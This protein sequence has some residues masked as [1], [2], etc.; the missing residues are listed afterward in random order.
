M[1]QINERAPVEYRLVMKRTRTFRD[2]DAFC[3]ALSMQLRSSKKLRDCTTDEA[4]AELRDRMKKDDMVVKIVPFD[5]PSPT[6]EKLIADLR[7]Q[8]GAVV[9]IV[10]RV[11]TESDRLAAKA[12]KAKANRGRKATPPAGGSKVIALPLTGSR[13]KAA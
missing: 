9:K 12:A 10:G 4:L 1:A 11:Q 8:H 2:A 3:S 5:E 6:V 13:R 7:R